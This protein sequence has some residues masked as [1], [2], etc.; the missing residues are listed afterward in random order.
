MGKRKNTCIELDPELAWIRLVRR[1]ALYFF[2][3]DVELSAK[4]LLDRSVALLARALFYEP[5]P[6]VKN[7]RS[8]ASSKTCAS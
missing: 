7:S 5:C 4:Y 6:R 1:F 3:R 2:N 8:R